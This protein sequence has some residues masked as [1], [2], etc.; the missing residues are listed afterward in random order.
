MLLL[1]KLLVWAVRALARSCQTLVLDNLALRHQLATLAHSGR[2]ARLGPLDLDHVT[3][4][5]RAAARLFAWA[6]SGWTSR[7][8]VSGVFVVTTA[9]TAQAGINMWTG[10]GPK[11]WPLSVLAI[12]PTQPATLYAA[13]DNYSGTYGGVFKSTDAASTWS[14][15]N[16]GPRG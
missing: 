3:V 8:L 7:L 6:A 11:P 10:H 14:A 9:H 1:L 13:T 5:N 12:D 16:T 2:R 15:A 4:L